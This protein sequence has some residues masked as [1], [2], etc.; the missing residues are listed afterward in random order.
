VEDN[1]LPTPNFCDFVSLDLG[2][3]G[4]IRRIAFEPNSKLRDIN[5]QQLFISF[6]LL[7]FFTIE[8]CTLGI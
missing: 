5:E 4:P 8:T 1:R 3:S 2:L 6:L 7:L